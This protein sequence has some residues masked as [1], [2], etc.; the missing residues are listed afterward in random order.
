MLLGGYDY[1]DAAA[2]FPELDWAGGHAC[3]LRGAD[4]IAE[5]FDLCVRR[6]LSPLRVSSPGPLSDRLAARIL[7]LAEQ[8]MG[9]RARELAAAMAGHDPALWVT[10]R[11]HVRCWRSEP[12]GLAN[13]FRELLRT[14]PGA[15]LVM[16]GTPDVRPAL[17]ELRGRLP[18]GAPVLDAVGLTL[19]ETLALAGR[20]RLFLGPHG[21][22]SWFTTI[23]NLPGVVHTHRRWVR[24]EPYVI[25]PRE[26][27][28]LVHPLPGGAV[29][30]VGEADVFAQ[31]YEADW[32]AVL[33]LTEELLAREES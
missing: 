20:C 25:N 16:D 1:L 21:N 6:R 13:V 9:P 11:S 22:N 14:R 32:R 19:H 30:D 26:N 29:T 23:A 24:P 3:R 27:S 4:A 31:D 12:E 7:N 17:E 18:K 28:A 10:L 33:R 2:L 8:R 5:V 15:C